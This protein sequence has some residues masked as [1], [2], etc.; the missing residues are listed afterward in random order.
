M[1]FRRMYLTL[2]LNSF[3]RVLS[4]LSIFALLALNRIKCAFLFDIIDILI[5]NV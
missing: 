2:S 3:F 5:H 4:A 1:L